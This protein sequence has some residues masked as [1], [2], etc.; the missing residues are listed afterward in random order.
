MKL[1]AYNICKVSLKMNNIF[2]FCP[3]FAKKTFPNFVKIVSK[4][5]LSFNILQ[6]YSNFEI[7]KVATF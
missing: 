2:D 4:E 7:L 1:T 3:K 6:K 5:L